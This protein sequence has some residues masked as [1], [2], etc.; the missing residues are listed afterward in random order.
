MRARAGM[1]RSLFQESGDED[2]DH[3]WRWVSNANWVVSEEKEG[4][5]DP[6]FSRLGNAWQ[7]VPATEAAHGTSGQI[8]VGA[9]GM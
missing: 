4:K 3:W 7:D 1:E 9:W 6:P 2:L 5:G 8:P